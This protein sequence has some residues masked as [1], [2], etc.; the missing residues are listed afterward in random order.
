M[1]EH[2]GKMTKCRFFATAVDNLPHCCFSSKIV[3]ANS[4]AAIVVLDALPQRFSVMALW[5]IGKA[6]NPANAFVECYN[7]FKWA[8]AH[9]SFVFCARGRATSFL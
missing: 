8:I 9:F 6:G 7:Y 3:R 4:K 5:V 1:T 2:I